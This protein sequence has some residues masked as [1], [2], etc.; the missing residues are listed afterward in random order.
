MRST[1]Q[2]QH[3]PA[4]SNSRPPP[5][6]LPLC[7]FACLTLLLLLLLQAI[8]EALA[9]VSAGG[10][11]QQWGSDVRA[12]GRRYITTQVRDS[13]PACEGCRAPFLPGCSAGECLPSL[14]ASAHH[15]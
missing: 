13:L 15:E 7:C 4:I 14:P 5:A 2:R 11:L 8:G 12:G 9:A 6:A 3:L 10:E 1:A